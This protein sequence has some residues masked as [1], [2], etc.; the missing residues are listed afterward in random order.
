[1]TA[2]PE[3]INSGGF[4]LSFFFVEQVGDASNL[5]RCGL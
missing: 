3:L 1:M 4:P 5:F 2:S